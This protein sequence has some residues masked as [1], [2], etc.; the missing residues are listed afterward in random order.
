VP[1]SAS[2]IEQIILKFETSEFD[3]MVLRVGDTHLRVVRRGA[4]ARSDSGIPPQDTGAGHV[5]ASDSRSDRNE[6]RPAG[7]TISSEPPTDPSP[8]QGGERGDTSSGHVVVAP[9][10]GIFYRTPSPTSD[11]F[12]ARGARVEPDDTVGLIEVMK[13]FTSVSAG[14]R[15]EV[16]EF[17]VENGE[18]VIK[19]TPLLRVR[20]EC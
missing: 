14:V 10:G 1:I 3:E 20:E 8:S 15:G 2:E 19:G 16:E 13:L 12:V 9:I 18:T 7:T 5:P 4:G 17:L 11:P 6:G